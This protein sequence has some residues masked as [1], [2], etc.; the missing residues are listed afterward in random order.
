[1]VRVKLIGDMGAYFRLLT[2]AIPILGGFLYHGVYD[3]PNY[4]FSCTSVFTNLNPTDAYRGAGRPE[5]S[6]AIERCMD[7]LAA[8]M[9]KDP[10]DIRRINFIPRFENGHATAAG[11]SFDSG[12]YEPALDKALEI[13]RYEGLRKE[14]Q[15][16]L[17]SG[18][19]PH[20]RTRPC[21]ID[22]HLVPT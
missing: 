17:E 5:A 22:G 6:Y 11:L 7:S 8:K 16:Q 14:Q 21:C 9:G 10:A 15:Q 18:S 1:A 4:S 2:P 12:N 20:H 3:I 13:Q 19:R